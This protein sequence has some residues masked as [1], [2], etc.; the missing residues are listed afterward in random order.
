VAG[1]REFVTG[2]V[3]T[4]ENT[5]DFLMKQAVLKFADAAARDTAL[6]T[7]VGG[8]NALREGMVAYL[9]DT[10]EVLAYD[11]TAW[12]S[13]GLPLGT[14]T[15]T[16]GQILAFGT[17]TSTWNPTDPSGGFDSSVTFTTS[18]ASWSVP[19]SAD[20][21][22]K[23]TCVGGGGGGGAR[24]RGPGST[25]GTSSFVATGGIN[26]SASGGAGGPG[27]RQDL[28]HYFN[29]QDGFISEN[30]GYYGIDW[31]GDNPSPQLG[32][33]GA[34]GFVV[35]EYVN[36]TG[37]STANVTVGAGGSGASGGNADG[38]NGGRGEVIVEYRAA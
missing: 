34:G 6:G 2:E 15:P 31:S 14:A 9:D 28:N 16:D 23:V 38:G 17:A 10:N 37:V 29:N 30:G 12:G 22:F 4:A 25:G 13:L 24:D 18:N 7:A 27:G 26:V 8:G 5:N 36:L 35:V 3:L 20:G 32:A 19:A 1:F 33:K 21:V 11:G